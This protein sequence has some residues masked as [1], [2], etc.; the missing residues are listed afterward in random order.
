[1]PVAATKEDRLTSF[2]NK[3]KDAEVMYIL[4]PNLKFSFS[5]KATNLRNLPWFGR[6]V[7]KCPNREEDCTNF[8]GL[9]RK[10]ELYPRNQ[11]LKWTS[12]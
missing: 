2:K 1:M 9:L 12:C 11:L 10:A 8:C 7:S 3:G 4:K 5:E 6:L